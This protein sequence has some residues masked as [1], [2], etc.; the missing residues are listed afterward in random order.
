MDAGEAA[1]TLA[2]FANITGMSQKDF[3]KL[4]STLVDLGN[5]Y[6]TTEGEIMTMAL[7]LAG[8]STQVG[9]SET[10]ILG[11]ATALSSV[12]IKVFCPAC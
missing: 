3:E 2:R 4:G 10:D 11:L 5:N 8:A 6:A 9:M 7:R 1:E 12:G